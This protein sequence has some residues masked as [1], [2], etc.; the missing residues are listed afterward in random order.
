MNQPWGRTR[1][2]TGRNGTA[3]RAH[4]GPGPTC[5]RPGPKSWRVPQPPAHSPTHYAAGITKGKHVCNV[6]RV[7]LGSNSVD[8]GLGNFHTTLCLLQN[9][10]AHTCCTQ[11]RKRIP[12]TP[13][14]V[15]HPSHPAQTLAHHRPAACRDTGN[16]PYPHTWSP[17]ALS[18]SLC[19]Q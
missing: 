1:Q 6:C 7:S 10:S 17:V 3:L 19:C 2:S 16:L 11:I 9:A 13:C 8:I 14:L 5:H 18:N 15:T 4:T 12:P